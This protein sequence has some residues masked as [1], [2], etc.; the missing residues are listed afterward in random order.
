MFCFRDFTHFYNP[1]H[2]NCYVFNSGWNSGIELKR[3]TRTGRTHGKRLLRRRENF[4]LLATV[5][6]KLNIYDH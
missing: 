1:L 2:G 6:K 5:A 3:S 4:V